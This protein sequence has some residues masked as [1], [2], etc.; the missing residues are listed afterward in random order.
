VA[1]VSVTPAIW[2]LSVS[3]R[4][5]RT[6]VGTRTCAERQRASPCA[7]GVA[8]VAATSAPASRAS[9]GGSTGRSASVTASPVPET[10]ASSAQVGSWPAR[11]LS[12]THAWVP[13]RP[14]K[15]RLSSSGG[16]MVTTTAVLGEKLGQT[17]P[18]SGTEATWNTNVEDP[19]M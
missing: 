11:L 5:G 4:K 16:G 18:N 3:A 9:S 17:L 2:A 13:F 7:A 6:R 14:P 10:R 1:C 19:A 12:Q 8:N 15:A